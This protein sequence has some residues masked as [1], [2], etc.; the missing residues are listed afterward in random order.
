MLS[1][2][3]GIQFRSNPSNRILEL[4]Q[5]KESKAVWLT[6]PCPIPNWGNQEAIWPL[7]YSALQAVPTERIQRLAK[8]KSNFS[9]WETYLRKEEEEVS[10]SRKTSHPSS[11]SA[12]YEHIV[13]LST[14]KIMPQNSQ[15]TGFDRPPHTSCCEHSCPIWH[16]GPRAKTAMASP[17]ILQLANPKGNH[18]NFQSNIET[19]ETNVSQ[20]AKT[21]QRSPRLELLSLPKLRN[22]NM[23]F[24]LG[25]PED[26]IWPVSVCA[27]R[28]K[29]SS[30]LRTLSAPKRLH[31]DYIPLR[32]LPP[33]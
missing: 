28:A 23:C 6:T 13:R 27:L 10:S 21:A 18:R 9:A 30:R 17:R 31:E 32:E 26:T 1:G 25:R 14:P 15:E 24:E 11:K 19:V 20:A 12:H 3:T 5:H 33:L 8:H 7:S 22:R 2:K 4:A 29:T 16:V